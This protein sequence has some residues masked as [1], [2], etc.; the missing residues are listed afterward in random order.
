MK[1]KQPNQQ[2]RLHDI[3]QA[4]EVA[5]E[6]FL[7]KINF[8]E[9]P[10]RKPFGSNQSQWTKKSS[11][12]SKKLYLRP[13]DDSK[14]EGKNT[15]LEPLTRNEGREQR[16][17]TRRRRKRNNSA[18]Q[19][20]EKEIETILER[21]QRPKSIEIHYGKSPKPKKINKTQ[22]LNEEAEEE[23][24]EEAMGERLSRQI[25]IGCQK[26]LEE[27]HK[28]D[29]KR[30]KSESL[31]SV[32]DKKKQ[33]K[34]PMRPQIERPAN[35]FL[36]ELNRVQEETRK[37]EE[38]RK[39][40]KVIL[41]GFDSITRKGLEKISK[42]IQI[43]KPAQRVIVRP[44]N[45][46][47]LEENRK[48]MEEIQKV[49]HAHK[50]KTE[51]PISVPLF[52]MSEPYE[53]TPRDSLVLTPKDCF[54]IQFPKVSPH[55]L[56]DS[57]GQLKQKE[58]S[59][60]FSQTEGSIEFLG[61]RIKKEKSLKFIEKSQKQEE[62]LADSQ[63][64]QEASII[65]TRRDKEPSIK[66]SPN[67]TSNLKSKNKLKIGLWAQE[68]W[69]TDQKV[70]KS[71]EKHQGSIE[72]LDSTMVIASERVDDPCFQE[73][74]SY[75]LGAPESPKREAEDIELIFNDILSISVS[76]ENK[77]PIVAKVDL[78][79][80]KRVLENRKIAAQ[81]RYSRLF[82]SFML[83]ENKDDWLVLK[84]QEIIS[85]GPLFTSFVTK[86]KEKSVLMFPFP[87]YFLNES[88]FL[89]NYGVS[90]KEYWKLLSVF[91]KANSKRITNFYLENNKADDQMCSLALESLCSSGEENAVQSLRIEKN[92]W[93]SEFIETFSRLVEDQSMSK[94][95]H[96]GLV[97]NKSTL[98]REKS[99]I[100]LFKS[101]GSVH[102]SLFT[103]QIGGIEIS[104]ESSHSLLSFLELG[105]RD[106]TKIHFEDMAFDNEKAV[107]RFVRK[108]F[109]CSISV[110]DLRLTRLNARKAGVDFDSKKQSPEE[111]SH[112]TSG[113]KCSP[114]K[115]VNELAWLNRSGRPG[116][117][118]NLKNLVHLNLEDS[119]L[120]ESLLHSILKDISEAKDK[121]KSLLCVHLPMIHITQDQMKSFLKLLRAEKYEHI[122][123]A[124]PNTEETECSLPEESGIRGSGI[125]MPQ[126]DFFWNSDVFEL[127][128]L[129]QIPFLNC[130]KE[131]SSY[132]ALIKNSSFNG[133]LNE[134]ESFKVS[135]HCKNLVLSQNRDQDL[136]EDDQKWKWGYSCW[137][138]E[139]WR[140]VKVKL[141]YE[142]KNNQPFF[143]KTSRTSKGISQTPLNQNEAVISAEKEEKPV[144]DLDSCF[145]CSPFFNFKPKPM[146]FS[147]VKK[148]F[149]F[150][151]YVPPGHLPFSIEKLVDDSRV[152]LA[153]GSVL[154]KP[155]EMGQESQ[156]GEEKKKATLNGPVELESS[157][158]KGMPVENDE[159][160][161][162][163]FLIDR[164]KS[165]IDSIL[166]R[167]PEIALFDGFV[168]RKKAYKAIYTL[169]RF[170]R[171]RSKWPFV[172][173]RPIL[174]LFAQKELF[175]KS[176]GLKE[177][178]KAWKLTIKEPEKA[179]QEE[180]GEGEY[181]EST[182]TWL[183][184][185]IEAAGKEEQRSNE[186]Q[187][188][189][190]GSLTG[191]EKE[192]TINRSQIFEFFF[193]VSVI[194]YYDSNR[195]LS[196]ADAFER[197]IFEDLSVEIEKTEKEVLETRKNFIQ[198]RI[199]NS[200]FDCNIH[201]IIKIMAKYKGSISQGFSVSQL[202]V[203]LKDS[204]IEISKEEMTRILAY[205]CGVSS[206]EENS[207]NEE[208]MSLPEFLE[209]LIRLGIHI[210][211]P[212]TLKT[213]SVYSSTLMILDQ[214]LQK[215]NFKA[216]RVKGYE[217]SDKETLPES[218]S[219]ENHDCLDGVNNPSTPFIEQ[220]HFE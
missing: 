146:S 6:P 184:E 108:V 149:E 214:L 147:F 114:T 131:L 163:L 110:E 119:E 82:S 139:H 1:G 59:N 79:F 35:Y 87:K 115:K 164:K 103:L 42:D 38:E 188:S 51:I 180:E 207:Q 162:H 125:R 123:L 18:V 196:H 106:L 144:E 64:N 65:L 159:I 170:F 136:D 73:E 205:S 91:L 99:V 50:K 158:F 12:A 133:K 43:F 31:P 200:L 169:F 212:K 5:E 52:P 29:K 143:E 155:R 46:Q 197:L 210:Y 48:E 60:L 9:I 88:F 8:R 113:K 98:K 56:E 161:D 121:G 137:F 117:L 89:F 63:E 191:T 178:E 189:H 187:I 171:A 80:V 129:D 102:L 20:E 93:G 76:G 150:V 140:K 220:D 104:Q 186:A 193:R 24:N 61:S 195:V 219:A 153:E 122:Y 213:E 112:S 77:N 34:F 44:E 138:C 190:L 53:K 71:M 167:K 23:E 70:L 157:I 216:V 151:C 156:M 126:L 26:F 130:P 45:L 15:R 96:I 215:F 183:G 174:D 49:I 22:V 148:E 181:A 13:E 204:R 185:T 32:K 177:F 58:A 132:P 97:N 128:Y 105:S 176:I 202:A 67:K 16:E 208:Q 78:E 165:K 218:K 141:H 211:P 41:N 84:E 101:L 19:T 10:E 68:N 28:R 160:F 4:I 168:K 2:K 36:K 90:S 209:F 134:N 111:K 27:V 116:V 154:V 199:M 57:K 124:K 3:I 206:L 30:P 109:Q 142:T 194:K 72:T 40:M 100:Q 81:K 135:K 94:L 85:S 203:L 86:T 66:L 175:D 201:L 37:R 83:S 120:E 69:K 47:I 62:S 172:S 107:S 166:K 198:T 217:Y 74:A 7:A 21:N 92:E 118:G 179:K 152:V 75:V 173:K 39:E 54:E 127:K 17:N 145:F 95:R 14:K 55:D 25:D 33:F 11:L 182:S 192:E